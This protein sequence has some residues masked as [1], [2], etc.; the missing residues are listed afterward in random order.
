LQQR[1]RDEEKAAQGHANA[2]NAMQ[3]LL[4]AQNGGILR[5]IGGQALGDAQTG[6]N[7]NQIITNSGI[8]GG[9]TPTYTLTTN[10]PQAVS[11]VASSLVNH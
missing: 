3:K 9:T 5:G 7:W 11:Y 6:Q 10:A 4:D 8:S 2:Q 1:A